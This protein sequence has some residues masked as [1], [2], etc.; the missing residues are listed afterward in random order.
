M[1]FSC[2][3]HL[4]LPTVKRIQD[5]SSNLKGITQKPWIGLK[6]VPQIQFFA[7]VGCLKN[8]YG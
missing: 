3:Q 8:N 6:D 4:R 2:L 7:V 1:G 5:R